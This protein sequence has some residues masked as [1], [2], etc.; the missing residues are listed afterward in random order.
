MHGI[1][2]CRHFQGCAEHAADEWLRVAFGVPSAQALRSEHFEVTKASNRR[3][4][5]DF[6]ELKRAAGRMMARA[7]SDRQRRV[8]ISRHHDRLYA[9]RMAGGTIY[10]VEQPRV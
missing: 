4:R 3:W 5:S 6:Q 8:G 10:G 7:A 9:D 1:A 2:R